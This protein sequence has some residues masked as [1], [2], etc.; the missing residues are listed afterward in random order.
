MDIEAKIKNLT[1]DEIETL[2]VYAKKWRNIGYDT[3]R[4][5]KDIA[6]K[7]LL[8]SYKVVGLQPFKEVIWV[9]SPYTLIIADHI[10][11]IAIEKE[12]YNQYSFQTVVSDCL[13]YFVQKIDDLMK[14]KIHKT[15]VYDRKATEIMSEEHRQIMFDV[16]DKQVSSDS[17]TLVNKL[18]DSLYSSLYGSHDTHWLA[19]FDFFEQEFGAEECKKLYPMQD[20]ARH[21]GWWIAREVTCLVS[22]K[23]SFISLNEDE[24]LHNETR[25]ALEYIDGFAVYSVDGVL[26]PQNVVEDPENQTLDEIRKESN[27]EIQRIRI[28]R[29]GWGRYLEAIGA[30]V[31]NSQL[32]KPKQGVEWMESLYVSKEENLAAL[33]TFDPST[34]R[35]YFLEVPPT[36]KTC[37]EAQA[38]LLSSNEALAGMDFGDELQLEVYPVLRT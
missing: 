22:E 27:V 15:K 16:I 30:T 29:Y 17:Y 7:A 33:A 5:N 6:N 28:T 1:A 24:E 38:Y 9:E 26:V 2:K 34:G 10:I 12:L 32:I 19:L 3:A 37:V 11:N 4:G 13:P 18:T 31:I 14:G 20:I 21:C 35:P 8:E 36:T 25:A 23:Q